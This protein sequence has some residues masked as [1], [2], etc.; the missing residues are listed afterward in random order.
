MQ[1]TLGHA[2]FYILL[3][4]QY[5]FHVYIYTPLFFSIHT[6]YIF[7]NN[8]KV[9]FTCK[10]LLPELLVIILPSTAFMYILFV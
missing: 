3:Y 2:I 1:E 5:V 10:H 8:Y 4:I 6:R 9:H 7:A